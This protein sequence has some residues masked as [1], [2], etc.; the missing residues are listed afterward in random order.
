MYDHQP[1]MYTEICRRNTKHFHWFQERLNTTPFS[2]RDGVKSIFFLF[3]LLKSETHASIT[4][5]PAA[6]K[7]QLTRASLCCGH[8][9]L[10]RF[11]PFYFAHLIIYNWHLELLK[12]FSSFSQCLRRDLSYWERRREERKEEKL[13]MTGCWQSDCW[14][15]FVRPLSHLP[16]C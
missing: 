10:F 13:A 11:T 5:S 3:F 15:W 9:L 14:M 4:A 1:S 7:N 6:K 16:A 8:S 2:L 12:P